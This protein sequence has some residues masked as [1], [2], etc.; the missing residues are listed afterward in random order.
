M[1]TANS[2]WKHPIDLTVLQQINQGT[3]GE[4]LAI[5]YVDSGPDFLTARMPVD[6]RTKQPDGLLHGGAS[7]VLAETLGS[8]ASVLCLADPTRQTAVGVEINANHLRPAI[9]GYVYGTV[10]P[11]RLGRSMHVWN[12]EIQDEQEKLICVSRLTIAVISRR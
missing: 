7:V 2:I 4:H 8:V 6:E 3:L 10:R 12:I 11:I 1:D 5:E 9:K